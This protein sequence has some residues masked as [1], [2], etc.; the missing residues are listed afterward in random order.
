MQ[1]P[2]R[3]HELDAYGH[4][5]HSTYLNYFEVGRIEALASVGCGLDRMQAAGFLLIVTEVHIRYLGPATLGQVLDLE[6]EVTEV[7]S[8]TAR[9][10]QAITREG[11]AI[12]SLELRGVF[13]DTQGRPRRIP[14]EYVQALG[15]LRGAG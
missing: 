9:W 13:A 15:P 11:V 2:V 4:V 7:R 10:R 5:N 1:L 6:T 14:D 3:F 12:A 8:A